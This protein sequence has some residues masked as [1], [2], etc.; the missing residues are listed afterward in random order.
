MSEE[1]TYEGT[2]ANGFRAAA[3]AAVAVYKERHGSPKGE[4]VTLRVVEMAVV[5]EN[6][7]RDYKVVLGGS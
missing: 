6:P 7:L 3:E 1:E 5:V 2:S 4:R